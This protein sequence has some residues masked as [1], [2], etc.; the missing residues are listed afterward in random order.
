MSDVYKK[1]PVSMRSGSRKRL[2]KSFWISLAALSEICGM[3]I[4]PPPAPILV[5][6]NPKSRLAKISFAEL[7]SSLML[8]FAAPNRLQK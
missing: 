1:P 7:M 5:W 3:K 4:T 6:I 8:D 2:H